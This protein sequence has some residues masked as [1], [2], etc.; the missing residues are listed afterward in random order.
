MPYIRKEDR[1]RYEWVIDNIVALLKEIPEDE[2]D[3]HVNFIFTTILKRVYEP[4][5]YKRYNAL[6]GVLSCIQQEF[7]RRFVV[8]YENQKIQ[9]NG[10]IE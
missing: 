2:R 9:E 1:K 5:K 10:D 4:P 3:G 8:S 6:M 7:Y